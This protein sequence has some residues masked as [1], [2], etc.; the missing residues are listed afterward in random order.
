[1]LCFA[2][3]KVAWD[4]DLMEFAA[5]GG[6]GFVGALL[7]GPPVATLVMV[8]LRTVGK[9]TGTSWHGILAPMYAWLG[10]AA[11]LATAAALAAIALSAFPRWLRWRHAASDPFADEFGLPR[12]IAPVDPVAVMLRRVGADAF[13]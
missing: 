4:R 6:A 9:M 2:F 8:C 13:V 7:V 3:C 1:M 12:G 11:L 5:I 10:L